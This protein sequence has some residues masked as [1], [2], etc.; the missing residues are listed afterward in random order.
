MDDSFATH[1][2]TIAYDTDRK[3]LNLSADKPLVFHAFRA[4]YYGNTAK[5][6]NLC[7]PNTFQYKVDAG[8]VISLTG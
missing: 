1:N 5:D 2:I 8:Q 4:V 6:I 7:S 3:A